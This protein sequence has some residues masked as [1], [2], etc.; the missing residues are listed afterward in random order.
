MWSGLLG[1]CLEKADH[2]FGTPTSQQVRKAGTAQIL[3]GGPH[4]AVGDMRVWSNVSEHVEHGGESGP[5]LSLCL[6]ELPLRMKRARPGLPSEKLAATPPAIDAAPV[7]DRAKKGH[8]L[9]RI[10]CEVI[11]GPAPGPKPPRVDQLRRTAGRLGWRPKGITIFGTLRQEDDGLGKVRVVSRLLFQGTNGR[12][13]CRNHF[14]LTSACKSTGSTAIRLQCLR[15]VTAALPTVG[16]VPKPSVEGGVLGRGREGGQER[17]V[18]CARRQLLRAGWRARSGRL[19]MSRS[20]ACYEHLSEC[21][22]QDTL[23][24]R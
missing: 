23:I 15:A 9:R 24:G 5:G 18:P 3:P 17:R 13:D 11:A 16:H 10:E 7:V 2:C 12:C 4:D 14:S 8:D 1:A 21:D 19:G 22:A 6:V 20:G